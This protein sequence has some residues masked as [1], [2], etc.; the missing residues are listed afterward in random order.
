MESSTIEDAI[1]DAIEDVDVAARDEMYSSLIF[2]CYCYYDLYSH[3]ENKRLE[4]TFCFNKNLHCYCDIESSFHICDGCFELL[5]HYI[6]LMDLLRDQ[7][8]FQRLAFENL[9]RSS[10]YDVK[11][12]NIKIKAVKTE[13][14]KIEKLMNAIKRYI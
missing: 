4:C 9:K 12:R 14:E 8:H 11:I 7:L 2:R 6:K 10:K 3:V 5:E 13:I 1:E